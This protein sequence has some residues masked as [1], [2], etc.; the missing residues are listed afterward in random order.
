MRTILNALSILV[1]GASAAMAQSN[2]DSKT[3][4]TGTWDVTVQSQGQVGKSAVTLVQKGDSL[5]GK[6]S[7]QQLGD[8]EVVGQVKGRDFSFAYSTTM[9]GQQLTMTVK[10]IVQNA[11]SL[12]GTASLGPMGGATFTARRQK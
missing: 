3:D 11:D 2:G 4:L 8:L 7:S 1:L 9:N 12:S 5:I 6:Y 10:G